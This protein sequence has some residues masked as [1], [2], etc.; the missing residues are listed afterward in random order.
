MKI[1]NTMSSQKEEF[2]ELEKGKVKMYSCGPTVYNYFHIGNARP[3]IVF[4]T[5]R[6]Y[7]EYIGYEV[8]F[9]QNFTDVDDKIIIKANEEGITPIQLADKYIEEYFKDAKA[10]GIRKATVHPRVTENIKEII[11][12]IQ[13][14]I[15]KGFAYVL[16]NDVYFEVKKFKE[17][18]K[19]SHKNIDDL[20]SGARIEIN[21]EK[22]APIDFALWKGKKEGEIGWDSP[23]GQGRPGWHIECSVM[24]NKYLGESIDIHSGGQDLIFPHHE[25]EIAQSEARSSHTFAN[26]W[27]HNGYINVDNEKMSK[28][29]GNF[30][31]VRDVLKEFD[32]D[33]L[34][35]FM[36]SAH[37]RSPINYS[38]DMLNQAK[39][40]LER[41][42]NCKNNLNFILTKIDKTDMSEQ[43]KENVAYLQE[44]K[45]NFIDKMNDDL[46][47]ADA[48]T[49][50][51]DLVKFANTNVS[52]DS[53]KV[54]VQQ[55]L[56]MLNELTGVLNI[57]MDKT[58]EDVDVAKIEELIEQRNIA[59][60][61]KDFAKADEIRDELKQMGIEIKD[62]RQGVQWSRI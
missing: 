59:K 27:M 61:S 30:F 28:S 44:C 41:I 46:N 37:Y 52:I 23:W 10:I 50:I 53:S 12:F 39:S 54:F 26:Y 49:A 2:K 48:I 24:S 16:G 11:D 35:F 6:N 17:Y 45:T 15:D 55:T 20:L 31:T 60:K 40:S 34:R 5:L 3:F 42:K 25:N 18:G 62:T 56:D 33:T 51:F 22:R 13:D 43:E 19:L 7:L 32:G 9:V 29:L 58:D 4:D 36:L 21:D 57:A 14:L 8:T 38:K 47:T 1:Y